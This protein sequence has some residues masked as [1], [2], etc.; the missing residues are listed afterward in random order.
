MFESWSYRIEGTFLKASSPEKNDARWSYKVVGPK[1][2]TLNLVC[3]A[4]DRVDAPSR[5]E[6]VRIAKGL[7]EGKGIQDGSWDIGE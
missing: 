1:G 7:F 2:S 4:G 6:I 5:R 3:Y